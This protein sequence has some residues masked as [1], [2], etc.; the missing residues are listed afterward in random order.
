MSRILLI[1]HDPIQLHLLGLVL[2][3]DYKEVIPCMSFDEAWGCLRDHGDPSAVILDLHLQEMGNWD[4]RRFI[5]NVSTYAHGSIPILALSSIYDEPELRQVSEDLGVHA[6]LS[7]PV[8]PHEFRD[9]VHQLIHEDEENRASLRIEES[10]RNREW[11]RKGVVEVEM[12]R[13]VVCVGEEP[14]ALTIST[15]EQS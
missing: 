13:P 12:E 9:C 8:G 10:I 3:C 5:E 1:H 4:C 15:V 14:T 6:F 7:F 2:E 11:N